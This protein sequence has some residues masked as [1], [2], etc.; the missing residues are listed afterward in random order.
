[1]GSASF[2]L[3]HHANRNGTLKGLVV[4]YHADYRADYR[5]THLK[6]ETNRPLLI[7]TLKV[8]GWINQY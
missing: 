5:A 3:R 1:M 6:D 4:D 8:G 2:L 7:G